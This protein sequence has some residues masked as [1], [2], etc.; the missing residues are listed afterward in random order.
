M[1]VVFRSCT[2]HFAKR[3]I[4]THV[5]KEKVLMV[6]VYHLVRQS[7]Y[8]TSREQPLL[9][10][11]GLIPMNHTLTKIPAIMMVG[12]SSMKSITRSYSKGSNFQ[13]SFWKKGISQKKRTK[14]IQMMNSNDKIDDSLSDSD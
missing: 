11:Y 4:P 6:H 3:G 12:I 2:D 14:T 9:L 5:T 13:M 1:D 7:F 8:P 10:E